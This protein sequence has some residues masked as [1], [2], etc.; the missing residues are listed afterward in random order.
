MARNEEE[1]LR[2]DALPS[3]P[4]PPRDTYFGG[5]TGKGTT[6]VLLTALPDKFIFALV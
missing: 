2:M 3:P 4:P 5:E 6:L 1:S